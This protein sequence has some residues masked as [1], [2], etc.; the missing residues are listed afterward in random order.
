VTVGDATLRP[1]LAL[2]LG[3]LAFE[4]GQ[5]VCDADVSEAGLQL[6]AEFFNLTP[7]VGP[8]GEHEPSKVGELQLHL[9]EPLIQVGAQAG[10][11]RLQLS[12]ELPQVPQDHVVGL[13]THA[14]KA[15]MPASEEVTP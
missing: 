11:V 5:P 9:H 7:E 3:H 4:G 6:G 15:T 12:A 14:S 1:A 8:R 13:V 2:Q 10:E